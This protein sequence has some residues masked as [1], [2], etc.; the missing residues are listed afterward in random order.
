MNT[1]FKKRECCTAALP[2]PLLLAKQAAQT[3]KAEELLKAGCA[4]LMVELV[5]ASAAQAIVDLAKAKDVPVVF[6][7]SNVD[8]AIVAGYDK[9]AVVN[10]DSETF[11]TIYA[12]LL[13][14]ALAKEKKGIYSPNEAADRNEDGTIVYLAIGDVAGAVE[15]LNAK[16]TEAGLPALTAAGTVE[17]ADTIA[18][19]TESS[20]TNADK[21]DMGLLS[22]EGQSI[23]L[24]L[25]ADDATAQDVLV[26]LQSLGYNKDRLTTHC[27]PVYTAG[28]T[29]DYKALVLSDR[30]EGDHKD[31]AVQEYYKSMQY[32]VDLRGVEPED[33][34][35]MIYNTSDII[36]KGR[37]TGTVVEDYDTISVAAAELLSAMLKGETLESQVSKV[38]YTSIPEIN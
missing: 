11:N 26:A 23:D 38:S 14:D 28:N 35:S 24:I 19:L 16:L 21:K 31:D 3:A 33:L 2:F 5:D 34:D 10:T 18:A 13:F 7:N 17:N 25:T 36:G 9:C 22:Y 12:E 27:I 30:P 37:L 4:A 32:I 8:E 1:E 20:Y 29:A 6:F 15:A